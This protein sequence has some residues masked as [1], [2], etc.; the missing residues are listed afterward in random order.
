MKQYRI[1]T[2]RMK[3]QLAKKDN[4]RRGS[5]KSYLSNFLDYSIMQLD[6]WKKKAPPIVNALMHYQEK[7]G[8]SLSNVIKEIP[9]VKKKK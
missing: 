2:D 5:L 3:E 8:D 9:C 6:R 1:D 7:T 4:V